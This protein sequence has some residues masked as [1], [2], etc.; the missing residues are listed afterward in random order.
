MRNSRHVCWLNIYKAMYDTIRLEL[1]D[2]SEINI[3]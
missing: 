1:A 3:T 2:L